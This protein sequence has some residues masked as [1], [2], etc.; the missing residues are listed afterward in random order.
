M[1]L[2]PTILCAA[3]AV[4]RPRGDGDDFLPLQPLNLSGSSNV[5]VRAVAQT[6]IV[7]FTPKDDTM[8]IHE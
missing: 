7:P 8:R 2:S 5:V 3:H 4:Q 6:V 1:K